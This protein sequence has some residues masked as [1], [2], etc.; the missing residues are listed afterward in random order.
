MVRSA[1]TAASS[2][3]RPASGEGGPCWRLPVQRLSASNSRPTVGTVF[4]R[5]KVPLNKWLLARYLMESS[6]KGVVGSPDRSLARRDLQDR[7]VHGAIACAKRWATEPGP[8][9]RRGEDVEA[10][11]ACVG[12]KEKN[13]RLSKRNPENRGA[14]QQ[15]GRVHAGGAQRLR[16]LFPR[17]QR[18]RLDAPV[19]SSRKNERRDGH[20]MTDGAVSTARLAPSSL[21]RSRSI[22]P[23]KEYVRGYEHS[24]TAEG[25]FSGPEA[26]RVRRLSPRKRGAPAPLP[27]RVRLQLVEPHRAGREHAMRTDEVL[28]G[29]GGKRLDLSAELVKART[30]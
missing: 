14:R 20:L 7:V 13:R 8:D 24:N 21:P 11:E 23:L 15:S 10:D 22:T 1:R 30:L 25:Y 19:R 12:G 3:K 27:G 2:T 28:R 9:G 29:I 5:S 18:Q 4:E 16:P 17:R 26:W 6:K